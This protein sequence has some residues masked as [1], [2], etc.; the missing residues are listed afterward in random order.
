MQTPPPEVVDKG[1]EAVKNYWRQRNESG[2]DYLCEAK[3]LIVGEAG[4][5]KT[6]LARKIQDQ[7]YEL[8][9]AE[10]S[11]EGIEIIRW[12]FPAAIRVKQEGKEKLIS[13]DFQVNVWDFGGQ[14]VYHATHQ[15][16]L[17]RRS[18]Y[19]LVADD[20]KEDTDFN[21]WLHAV[22]LLSEG[23]PVLI[24]Q[25]EKQNRRR[26]INLGSLRGRFAN[27]KDAYRVNLA[28]N[29][30]L[31][32]LGIAI[33]RELETLSHI[34]TPLPSTWRR[35]REALEKESRNYISAEDYLAICRQH[36]FQRREDMMQLSGYLHD[37]GICLHFQDDSVLRKTVILKPRWGT[38]AVYRVLDD[39]TILER[40]GRFGPADLSRIWADDDYADMRDELLQL[41]KKFNLCYE[42]PEGGAYIAPQ[43]LSPTQPDYA[44]NAKDN[45]ML[46]YEYDFMPKG[47]MTR[48]IVAQNRLIAGDGLVWK[49]GV[50]LERD[51]TRAE[52]MEDYIRR[53]ISVRLNGPDTRGLL[54]IVDDQLDRIHGTFPHLKYEK[55]V[56]CNCPVCRTKPEPYAYPLTELKVF[57]INND[58]IQC[59]VSR[60]LVDAAELIR[61][62]LPSA[63]R[64]F[65]LP[66]ALEPKAPKEVF[67]SYAWTEQSKAVVD[68]IQT[69]LDGTGI[70]FVRDKDQVRYKDSIREFMRR[71][72]EGKAIVVV[73]SKRYLESKNC[74]FELTEIAGH[75]GIRDRVFP[76]IL[77]GANIFE[78][79]T[80]LDY[81]AY[82]ERKKSDLDAKQKGVGGENLGGIR[83]DL[84]LYAK[85]R[86]TIAEIMT[87]LADMNGKPTIEELV[88]ALE[89]RLED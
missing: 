24:V 28:D 39:R 87:I 34:G 23:S 8:K 14:E 75:E 62:V 55:F 47:L 40:R 76:I 32:D 77:E 82:W 80:R 78:S 38:D 19:V 60:K 68:Q 57:A 48:F 72:G 10:I 29:R 65:D 26:D 9:P 22:E 85:I 61:D 25:N 20:R 1:V 56:P 58:A 33:R 59:R 52:V 49:T 71:I 53:N 27:L 50:V 84:D 73:L 44:W 35:V 15:F 7:S 88:R 18:L 67:V 12:S 54:A 89:D 79:E 70:T 64:P 11:T 17:T 37:L 45:L 21:Y 66:A 51:G 74:M 3:L 42:L 36:N 41:M 16:F 83:E 69:A 5:G 30:G 46:R 86:A 13:R 2:V 81:I 4:A 43:L 31:L 63:L 6:S